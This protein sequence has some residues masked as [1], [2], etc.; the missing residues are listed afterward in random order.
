MLLSF[1]YYFN[2]DEDIGKRNIVHVMVKS[3]FYFANYC[4]F[5]IQMIQYSDKYCLFHN[6]KG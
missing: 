3:L 5:T 6:L 4:V 2:K 1:V